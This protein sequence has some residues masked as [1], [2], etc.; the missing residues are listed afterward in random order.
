MTVS[1]SHFLRTR[2]VFWKTVRKAPSSVLLTVSEPTPLPGYS[3]FMG[4]SERNP[5]TAELKCLYRRDFTPADR[6]KFG[7]ARDITAVIYISPIDLYAQFG[8]FRLDWNK[9][10]L[11]FNGRRLSVRTAR[12]EGE[13]FDS[14]VSVTLQCEPENKL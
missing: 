6:S 11:T 13:I 4:E 8:N 14:C 1:R 3:G 7:I 10:S 12:Y 2:E 5:T 9:V